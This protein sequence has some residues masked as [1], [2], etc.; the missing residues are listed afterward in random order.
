MAAPTA[1]SMSSSNSSG[2]QSR[3]RVGGVRRRCQCLVYWV[4]VLFIISILCWSYYAYVAQLCLLT[5]ANI[6]EKVVCLIAYH[7]FFMMFVWSYWQTIFILPSSPA[8]EFHLTYAGK[9]L[10]ER[11]SRSETHQEVLKRLAK[12]LPI[13]TRTMSGAIRYCD[14]CQ[15]IKP[16]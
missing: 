9:E 6:G 5:M 16:D 4:P 3:T 13:Y 8:K 7:L 11:E 10:L 12:D 14:R 1:S 2:Y 15:L